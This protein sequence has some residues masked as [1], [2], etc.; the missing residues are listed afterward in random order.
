MAYEGPRARADGILIAGGQDKKALPPVVGH[1]FVCTSISL[2]GLPSE[3]LQLDAKPLFLLHPRSRPLA[4]H[5]TGIIRL[6][7]PSY[8]RR[9]DD[10]VEAD[11]CCFS[12]ARQIPQQV[13]ATDPTSAA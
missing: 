11:R 1:P 7:T 12:R 13:S 8:R 9:R 2:E 4:D 3:P 5:A 10:E 6:P